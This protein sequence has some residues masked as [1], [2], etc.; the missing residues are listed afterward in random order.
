MSARRPLDGI[1]IADFSWIG[2]GSFATKMLA[3]A[4]ADVIKIESAERLDSLRVAPPF[5]DRIKGVNRSGYFSDRNTSKRSFTLNLKHPDARDIALKLIAQSDIV[6]NNFTPGVMERFGLGYDA[7]RAVK[8]NII[9]VA[10]SMQGSSGPHSGY[11]GYGLTIGALSGLH[12]LSGLPDRLPAGTG[13][14]YP[15]HMPNPCHAVFAVLAAVRHLRRTGE[16]QLIDI[17]QTEPTIALLASAVLDY[18]VNGRN[19][20]RTGNA[21]AT[22]CPHGAFPCE[23]KDRWIAIA[24]TN[25]SQWSA[26]VEALGSPDWATDG[27]WASAEARIAGREELEAKLAEATRGWNGEE[28]MRTLQARGVPAGIVNDAADLIDRD[29]QLAHRGHWVRLDHAEMGPTIYNAPPYRF[30]QSQVELRAPAPLLGQH[31]IEVLKEVLGIDAEEG[32]KLIEQ[33]VLV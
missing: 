10:M 20:G 3:D 23:G 1:R 8:P 7:V 22:A 24:V 6:A 32:A 2:A 17:A 4:G 16:G 12:H 29:P 18:T 13:T 25:D 14:N 9:Y 28:L 30:S 15:D 26:L 27:R 33:G 31:T 11:L 5:K 19:A 21:S